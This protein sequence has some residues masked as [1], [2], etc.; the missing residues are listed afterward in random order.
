MSSIYRRSEQR[1]HWGE[2]AIEQLPRE[3]A[4]EHAER[5]LVL[6]G[7]SVASHARLVPRVRELLGATVVAISTEVRSHSPSDSVERV[8]LALASTGADS[9]VVIG[10]GS[11]FVT[12]RAACVLQGEGLPLSD[13]APCTSSAGEVVRPQLAAP[14]L[15]II[16][17]PTTPTTA[18][19]KAGA[20]VT[21]AGQAARL[22]MFDPKTRARAILIDPEY[23][24]SS[25]PSLVREAALNSL[26]MAVEGLCSSRSNVFS[27]AT[28]AHATR[29]LASLI[30]TLVQESL[31][32]QGRMDATL[33]G[34][35]VGE[36]TD[37]SGGGV[38]AALS[39]TI[40]HHYDAHNGVVDAALLP[41]VLDH[42]RPGP[43]TM[44][45]L[46]TALGCDLAGVTPTLRDLL[47]VPAGS[48]RLRDLGVPLRDIDSL[49]RAATTDAAYASLNLPRPEHDTLVDI[50]RAAW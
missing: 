47:A 33:A 1:V 13:L 21:M 48:A 25:P 20:A 49:A 19:N 17:I 22:A 34:L 50:L 15:P 9:L 44:K 4:R 35:L 2:N 36:G 23:L 32:P 29:Q 41:H 28:L 5:T 46:S 30:P 3:L 39:H 38:T 42:V 14:K 10:G 31:G 43:E 26:V 12:A 18:T 37:I 6:C 8:A 24:A 11:A 7:P 16:A 40:G 45:R 27:D